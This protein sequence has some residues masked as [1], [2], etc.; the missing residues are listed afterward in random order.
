[1]KLL[2]ILVLIMCLILP[3]CAFG[4]HH[5]YADAEGI[6]IPYG[7]KFELSM[8]QDVTT[9]NLVQGDIVQAYLT[10][11]IYVNNKL[12]LPSKTIFRGRVVA[13]KPS[14]SFSRPASLTLNLDHLVTKYGT[15]LAINSGIASNFEYI[16]KTDG[17]LTTNGNYFK[18]TGQDLVKSAKIL[19]KTI[20]WGATAG[21][22]LFT[23]AK[24]LFVPVAFVGGTV[25]MVGS[26]VYNTIANL[27]RHGDEIVIRKG[28]IFNIILLSRLD[29]PS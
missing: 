27:F 20:K 21:D 13:M 28:T 1:M 4:L 7:T 22:E 19:P 8:A 25:A 12:I 6:T 18:A 5:L 10:K 2:K 3:N 11:D 17:S 24:I 15:Q 29:V 9:K 23:G 26:G 16:L 14:R